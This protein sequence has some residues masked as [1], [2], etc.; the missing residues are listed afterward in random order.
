MPK[1]NIKLNPIVGALSSESPLLGDSVVNKPSSPGNVVLPPDFNDQEKL[2]QRALRL[3][4]R[5]REIMIRNYRNVVKA[6]PVS[7]FSI[8]RR[9]ILRFGSSERLLKNR[10]EEPYLFE[11]VKNQII[12]DLEKE[13][14]EKYEG[15]IKRWE[16]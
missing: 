9:L 8:N 4:K 10:T 2:K 12:E 13:Q 5:E 11:K 1:E 15:V 7:N 3:L 14:H 6:I 16:I